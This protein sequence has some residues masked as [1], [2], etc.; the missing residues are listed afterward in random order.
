MMIALPIHT[1]TPQKIQV[2]VKDLN[3]P[4]TYYT[5]RYKTIK[6]DE[7]L[8]VRMP[9]TPDAIVLSVFNKDKG[10]LKAGQDNSF[11]INTPNGKPKIEA[12]PKS[13]SFDSIDNSLIK[14][15]LKFVTQFCQQAGVLTAGTYMSDD[16]KFVIKY[17]DVIKDKNGNILRTPARISKITGI[18]EVSKEKFINYTV[19]MRIVILLHEFSHFYLN[20]NMAD[21]MEA[22]LNALLMYLGLGFPRIEAHEAFS[23]VFINSPSTLNKNR[24]DVLAKF[25]DNFDKFGFKKV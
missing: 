15:Y 7:T 23:K 14:S 19:P 5:N 4:N 16:K 11:K 1:D 21:E 24:Y 25:I 18:I 22:D 17:L 2:V 13:F 10:N 12:L 8:Y 6:G 3:K 9:V 20:A